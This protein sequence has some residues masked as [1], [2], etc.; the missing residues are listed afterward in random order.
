MDTR[1]DVLI[2]QYILFGLYS[3]LLFLTN[4]HI[5]LT[6][7][8]YA[9]TNNEQKQRKNKLKKIKLTKIKLE[10][11]FNFSNRRQFYIYMSKKKRN[12]L[13]L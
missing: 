2:Q 6:N 12:I 4:E 11:K 8:E 7:V 13:N 1:Q 9:S 3:Y 5:N 10:K